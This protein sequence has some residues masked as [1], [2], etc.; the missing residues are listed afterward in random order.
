M[1]AEPI[2]QRFAAFGWQT[3][4][5][6]GHDLAALLEVFADLPADRDGPPQLIVADTV[7]GRGVARM[8]L[9][10]DWHVGNLV[11]VDYDDVLAELAAGP[12]PREDR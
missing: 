4:R 2:E 7:K 5:V 10:T 1:N 8:E 6:D 3:R 9:S 11:G 12:H